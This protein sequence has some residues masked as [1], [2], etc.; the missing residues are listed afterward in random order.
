[1]PTESF[2]RHRMLT[3]LCAFLASLPLQKA[4]VSGM[5]SDEKAMTSE[6]RSN[7]FLRF[8]TVIYQALRMQQWTVC[9]ARGLQVPADVA[10]VAHMA[11]AVEQLAAFAKQIHD[12][13]VALPRQSDDMCA[14]LIALS[15]SQRHCHVSRDRLLDGVCRSC[16][17]HEG[18][19]RWT[20]GGIAVC[21]TCEQRTVL[22]Q[23]RALVP[24]PPLPPPQACPLQQVSLVC[25]QALKDL[26]GDTPM[27]DALSAVRPGET[28]PDLE[29]G[30]WMTAQRAFVM[31]HLAE[32]CYIS[33]SSHDTA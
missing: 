9:A 28:P 14:L 30:Q 3:F 4:D 10:R 11:Y 18:E 21:P 1:M 25:N 6:V 15:L 31:G 19:L 33:D 23:D 22:D 8:A 24:H 17:G 2:K 26:M 29:P 20:L 5:W 32:V 13:D 7:A 16:G 27:P 12:H